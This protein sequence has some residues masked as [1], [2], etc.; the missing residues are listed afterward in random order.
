MSGAATV[1]ADL[2]LRCPECSA[3][4]RSTGEACRCSGCG[5]GFPVLL[6]IPDLRVPVPAWIDFEEDRGLARDLAAHY[7]AEGSDALIA[8]LLARRTGVPGGIVRRRLDEIGRAQAKYAAYLAPSGWIGGRLG[9]GVGGRCLEVGCGPG[10]FLFPAA[11]RFADVV[12]VDISLAWLV[13]A[14]KRLGEHGLSSPIVCA[15]VE[16]LPLADAQFDLVVAFDT[17]EHVADGPAMLREAARVTRVGGVIACTTPNR[18]SLSGEPH[19][20]LWGIGFL[21]RAWM[22]AYVRWR[23]GMTYHH[24]HPLSLLDIHRLLRAEPACRWTCRAAGISEGDRCA[25]RRGKRGMAGLYNRLIRSRLGRRLALPVA[26]FFEILG[27]R[28]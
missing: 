6:G 9:A 11:A 18:F 16:R 20:G 17:I 25:F 14:K 8:R 5:R 21:P 24:T 23:N 22:P 12:G 19:V 3:P 28:R 26:P 2:A 15:C 27:R 13:I 10:S 1:A 4:V 7:S